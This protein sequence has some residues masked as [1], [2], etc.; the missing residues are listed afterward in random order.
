MPYNIL[1]FSCENWFVLNIQVSVMCRPTCV[2]GIIKFRITSCESKFLSSCLVFAPMLGEENLMYG[3][4][5]VR[6]KIMMGQLM[7]MKPCYL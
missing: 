1:F 4:V 2:G 6:L 5:D 7:M 3:F